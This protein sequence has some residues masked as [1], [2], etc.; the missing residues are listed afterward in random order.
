M[1]SDSRPD[2]EAGETEEALY[3]P[4]PRRRRGGCVRWLVGFAL[5][6]CVGGLCGAAYYLFG[7]RTMPARR[8]QAGNGVRAAVPVAGQDSQ[9][10]TEGGYTAPPVEE[11]QVRVF[12]TPDGVK[13]QAQVIDLPQAM[14]TH[15]RLRF[16]MEELLR[17]PTGGKLKSAVPEGVQLRAAFIRDDTAV[18]DLSAAATRSL[19][20]PMAEA[21]CAYAV[22]NTAALNLAGVKAARI[23]IDGQAVAVLWEQ[24][25]LTGPLAPDLSLIQR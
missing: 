22:V 13:L 25:D 4:P 11:N 17:G 2:D 3:R 14:S 18:V 7:Y 19:G 23:L 16:A 24:V 12:F 5:V 15:E 9:A 21:L 6:A 1:T 10:G 8:P 20:G